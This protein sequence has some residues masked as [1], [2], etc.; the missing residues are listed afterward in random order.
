MKSVSVRETVT[1]SII[2]A[3]ERG[4]VP[5][6]KPWTSGEAIRPSPQRREPAA[7]SRRQRPAALVRGDE[8]RL[9]LFRL[10][11]C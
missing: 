7:L 1:Y 8:K 6:V 9:P 10:V 5:W 11:D 2:A 3:L 4:V